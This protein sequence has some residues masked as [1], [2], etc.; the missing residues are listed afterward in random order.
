MP[1]HLGKSDVGPDLSAFVRGSPELKFVQPCVSALCFDLCAVVWWFA[2]SSCVASA[3]S[4]SVRV[5]WV[6]CGAAG[7]SSSVEWVYMWSGCGASSGS[8][9]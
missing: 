3:V 9:G 8:S 1:R 6:V 5:A 4:E 7:D 2:C